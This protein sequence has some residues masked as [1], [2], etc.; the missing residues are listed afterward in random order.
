MKMLIHEMIK[1][2]L[3]FDVNSNTIQINSDDFS[4]NFP[5]L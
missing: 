4:F 5:L 3:Q 2:S 1:Y